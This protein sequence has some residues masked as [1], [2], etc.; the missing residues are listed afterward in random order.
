MVLPACQLAQQA[1][2]DVEREATLP[3]PSRHAPSAEERARLAQQALQTAQSQVEQQPQGLP[4]A[5]KQEGG[6]RER[7]G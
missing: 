2:V 5:S 7:Q 1:R 4:N 6:G 3:R